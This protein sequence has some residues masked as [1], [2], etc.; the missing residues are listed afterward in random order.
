MA[1]ARLAKGNMTTVYYY[2]LPSRQ[3]TR[4][5]IEVAITTIATLLF[6]VVSG[7]AIMGYV[8][9]FGRTVSDRPSSSTQHHRNAIVFYEYTVICN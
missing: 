6:I 9:L 3:R 8:A 7:F 5:T 4:A 1:M 2:A